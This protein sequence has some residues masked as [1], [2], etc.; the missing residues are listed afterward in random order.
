MGSSQLNSRIFLLLGLTIFLISFLP[1]PVSAQG[2]T[3]IHPAPATLEVGVGQTETWS[4]VI[5]GVKDLYGVEIR[6][7][8]DPGIVQ[9]ASSDPASTQ[10]QMTPG[11]F[12]KPDFLVRN[13]VDN[14]KGTI[15][16]VLTQTNPTPPAQGNG[17]LVSIQ[18]SGKIVGKNSPFVIDHVKF[19]DRN[20]KTIPVTSQNGQI[21]VVQP[22]PPTPT[23]VS[24]AAPAPTAL[25]TAQTSAR[26][27]DADSEPAPV[28]RNP[29]LPS[30]SALDIAL[31][32]VGGC[33]FLGAVLVLGVGAFLYFKRSP[34]RRSQPNSHYPPQ[35]R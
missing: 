3:I 24:I 10:I 8:F 21:A 7:H 34:R 16:F 32:G 33:G 29:A 13:Q 5:E 14:A 2:K 12:V 17:T 19:S 9:V 22:K 20:G 28:S 18:F 26:S 31:I 15:E 27:D 6:A 11:D 25:P 23:P 4:L 30:V 35:W 1:L